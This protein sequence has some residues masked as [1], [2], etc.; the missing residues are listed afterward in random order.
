MVLKRKRYKG[1]LCVTA[2]E[3]V[4]INLK[5]ILYALKYKAISIKKIQLGNSLEI[6]ISC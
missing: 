1:T 2:L 5:T 4:Y 6:L 3:S